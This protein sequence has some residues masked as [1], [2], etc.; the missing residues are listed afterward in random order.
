MRPGSGDQILERKRLAEHIRRAALVLGNVDRAADDHD[1]NRVRDQLVEELVAERR[2][3]M[4]IQEDEC[5]PLLGNRGASLGHALGVPHP[6]ALQLEVH[7]AE[8][9]QRWVVLD[10]EDGK[11]ALPHG[12]A[13][14]VDRPA[15]GLRP[16]HPETRIGEGYAT[17]VGELWSGL[18]HTLV[19]LEALAGVREWLDTDDATE[20]LQRLQYRLHAASEHVFG[21]APP[22]GAESAHSELAAAL[23]SARDATGEVIETLET[24]GIEAIDSIVHEWRGALFRV[25]LARLRLAGPRYA[26]LPE[27]ERMPSFISPLLACIL[28]VVG[29]AAFAVGAVVGPWPLWGA[30]ILRSAARCSRTALKGS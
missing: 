27:P 26:T 14:V 9:A 11:S 23:A 22:A 25:R 29:V 16:W 10:D 2:A 4:N 5:R 12:A 13:I 19:R 24:D 18:A 17:Q 8:Q 1:R 30:G 20:E 28:T 3:E 21:L 7:P 15:I 6:E